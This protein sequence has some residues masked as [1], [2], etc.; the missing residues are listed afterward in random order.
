MKRNSKLIVG[1]AALVG[2]SAGGAGI[3]VAASSGGEAPLEGNDLDRAVAAALESTGGGEV[4]ETEAGD[5]GAAYEVEIRLDDGTQVEINLDENFEVTGSEPDD[6][7]PN[8]D[9][10]DDAGDD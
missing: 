8:D 9:G 2:L 7:G 6:D 10:S 1:A 5:D 4:T 3:A